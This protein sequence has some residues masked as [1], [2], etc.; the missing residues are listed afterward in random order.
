MPEKTL[1]D[2]IKILVNSL[3]ATQRSD[4]ECQ[5]KLIDADLYHSIFAIA[6]HKKIE[7][8]MCDKLLELMI[9][10]KNKK[11]DEGELKTAVDALQ[12]YADKYQKKLEG[13]KTRWEKIS[14]KFGEWF[15][16]FGP[17]SI[18]NYFPGQGVG[19]L[20]RLSEG[21]INK[22]V[23]EASLILR[24]LGKNLEIDLIKRA[25][26]TIEKNIVD[27]LGRIIEEEAVTE[28]LGIIN[29]VVKLIAAMCMVGMFTFC[30][31]FMSFELAALSIA[32]IFAFMMLFNVQDKPKNQTEGAAQV[33]LVNINSEKATNKPKKDSSREVASD[34]EF[35]DAPEE[36]DRDIQERLCKQNSNQPS[37]GN[38]NDIQETAKN[39]EL[40]DH[41]PTIIYG[42]VAGTAFLAGAP[43]CGL[44]CAAGAGGYTA[45]KTFA[46]I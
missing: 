37:N 30:A 36:F 9:I 18:H 46:A 23:D 38:V 3:Y 35:V 11:D 19:R 32:G 27:R 40:Y 2:Q 12:K 16:W 43:L 4:R 39:S 34:D 42:A 15:E 22:L 21:G 26:N 5:V 33:G 24:R 7:V 45:F 6:E 17:F 14:D 8:E 41:I 29:V 44:L 10:V 20:Y 25:L 1:Q 13:K 31:W 28:V